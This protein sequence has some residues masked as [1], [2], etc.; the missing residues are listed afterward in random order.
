[1]EP[2]SCRVCGQPHRDMR[3]QALVDHDVWLDLAYA[4]DWAS[5]IPDPRTPLRVM[6]VKRKKYQVQIIDAAGMPVGPVIPLGYRDASQHC[7]VTQ[8]RLLEARHYRK[9]PETGKWIAGASR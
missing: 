1:M 4:K 6:A 7:P 3:G 9:D 8:Q 5:L 2:Q